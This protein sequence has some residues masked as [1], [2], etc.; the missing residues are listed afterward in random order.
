MKAQKV[1]KQGLEGLFGKSKKASNAIISLSNFNF[2]FAKKVPTKVLPVVEIIKQ[3]KGVKGL[4][5]MKKRQQEQ[6]HM[7]NF[8]TADKKTEDSAKVT[9]KKTL[10]VDSKTKES[11]ITSTI[12]KASKPIKKV[13][14][15][16]LVKTSKESPKATPGG[17]LSKKRI[18]GGKKSAPKVSDDKVTIS[19]S[20][21]EA[22]IKKIRNEERRKIMAQAKAKK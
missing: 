5:D 9:V 21:F 3:E 2:N 7:N 1:E 22:Y 13:M 19:K 20:D 8:V 15:K 14:K 11:K 12:K 10:Q 4:E 18:S 17:N 16:K 6:A